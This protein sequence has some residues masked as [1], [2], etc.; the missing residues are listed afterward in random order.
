MDILTRKEAKKLGLTKHFTGKPCKWGHVCQRWTSSGECYE[1]D[2]GAEKIK[3]HESFRK[4][5][6]TLYGRVSVMLHNSKRRAAL[7]KLPF[8]LTRDWLTPKLESGVCEVTGLSFVITSDNV[9]GYNQKT[10]SFS[11]SLDRIDNNKG[12]TQ[13]NV[14]VVCWIYN[15]AKGAF[16]LSDLKLMADNLPD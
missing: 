3:Q 13:D 2:R 10:N 9:R 16:P 12:Y 11:P 7:K 1:C 15:R 8:D 5:Y 14:Q 6:A 4:S